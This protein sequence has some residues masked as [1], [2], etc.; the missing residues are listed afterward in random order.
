VKSYRVSIFA[1]INIE[2]ENELEA[3]EQATSAVINNRLKIS[4]YEFEAQDRYP[5]TG[6]PFSAYWQALCAPNTL[7]DNDQP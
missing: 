5:E 7:S 4:E 2:A 6:S 3:I 1:S